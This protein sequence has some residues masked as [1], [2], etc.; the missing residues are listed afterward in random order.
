MVTAI[1]APIHMVG[2]TI[3]NTLME[4]LRERIVRDEA[5]APIALAFLQARI[6]AYDVNAH[7]YFNLSLVH[8]K[9]RITY[10]TQARINRARDN[11]PIGYDLFATGVHWRVAGKPARVAQAVTGLST[12]DYGRGFDLFA[13]QAAAYLLIDDEKLSN[14]RVV[15]GPDITHWYNEC[16]HCD[17]TPIGDLDTSCMRYDHCQD[18][19][20]I[21]EDNAE[22]AILL[23]PCGGVRA[24]CLLWTDVNG[25]RWFDRVYGNTTDQEI[26]RTWG[27]QNGYQQLWF[28][29][30]HGSR[31][32]VTVTCPDRGYALAPYL[33]SLSNWCR[34]CAELSTHGCR[35]SSHDRVELHNHETGY[36]GYQR[37]DD[38]GARLDDNE[39]CPNAYYCDGCDEFYH[40]DDCPNCLI[41]PGCD[42][43]YA[44]WRGR[45][46]NCIECP[47]CGEIHAARDWRHEE[48]H[49]PSRCTDAVYFPEM[50]ARPATFSFSRNTY[51]VY[52]LPCTNCY[53]VQY[54]N[55]TPLSS[56]I[57]CGQQHILTPPPQALAVIVDPPPG[58][59]PRQR[60]IINA[61]LTNAQRQPIQ[62]I[63]YRSDRYD[64]IWSYVLCDLD[65][66]PIPA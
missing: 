62:R 45:Q 11:G 20:G 25:E 7:T 41:C 43:P 59:R 46:C 21:Y 18:R 54:S 63:D 23:C 48:G 6:N 16:H 57:S 26:L 14:V 56:C 13:Q 3:G 27:T 19:F 32:Q 31:D 42:E 35:N 10:T 17:C 34:T 64:G 55:Q 33:D 49:C 44:P 58:I 40:G 30:I 38:C 22:M 52:Q 66:H 37:C 28:S 51:Y 9:P 24:R 4:F 5:D 8:D 61:I 29:D 47:E 1:E 2:V 39:Y 36:I 12:N 15:T 53:Y 50:A 60:Q 65:W